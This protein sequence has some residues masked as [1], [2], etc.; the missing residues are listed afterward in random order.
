MRHQKVSEAEEKTFYSSPVHPITYKLRTNHSSQRFL[1]HYSVI[2]T[3]TVRY[4]PGLTP[5]SIEYTE[6][7]TDSRSYDLITEEHTDMLT[8]SGYYDLLAEA[9]LTMEDPD[10][11]LECAGRLSES[12]DT[13]QSVKKK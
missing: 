10:T 8:N 6:M 7:H 12:S 11:Y 3:G 13:Q 1:F 5:G 4:G 9:D 2:E